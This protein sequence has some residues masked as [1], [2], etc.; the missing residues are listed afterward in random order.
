MAKKGATGFDSDDDEL[1]LPED[2]D[3][4]KKKHKASAKAAAPTR[5]QQ[6]A[7]HFVYVGTWVG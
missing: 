1:D 2:S 5:E 4:D 6:I 7:G 3:D